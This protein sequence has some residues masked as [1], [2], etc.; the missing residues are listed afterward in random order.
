MTILGIDVS[1]WQRGV[2]MHRV[3]REGFEYVI[4][5]A[6]EGAGYRN[7]EYIAQ[8][9]GARSAGLA[10]CAYHYV[11]SD[12]A[13]LAQV[14]N[15][16]RAETDPQVPVMLDHEAG[17]GSIDVLRAVHAEF[18][19]RGHRVVLL[20]LPRWYW[21][22]QMGAPDL[23]GLPAL[24]SSDYG[25]ERAGYAAAIYPGDTDHGW[26]GYGSRP[27]AIFQFTQKACVAGLSLDA[28]AFRGSRA[29]L[30]ALFAAPTNQGDAM[31]LTKEDQNKILTG[32]SQ[33]APWPPTPERPGLRQPLN[34]IYN[35]RDV[36][37]GGW[38][39]LI[40]ADVWNEVVWDGYPDPVDEL[41]G[42]TPDKVRRRSLVGY[43]IE[44]Y[45]VAV[46]NGRK[47]DRLLEAAERKA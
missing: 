14:D 2:D 26:S 25:P 23:S 32:A 10:F 36:V 5:K 6:T 31:S 27:V 35:V 39:W 33:L 43:V 11:T 47:L 44:L 9:A 24:M 1:S 18:V 16:E 41:D 17:S 30:D 38:A 21:S 7:P 19:R 22:G 3:A 13:A 42:K 45:K 20:Y 8:R 29:E 40:L 28:S 37:R 34:L 12:A 46:L 15:F 4:A